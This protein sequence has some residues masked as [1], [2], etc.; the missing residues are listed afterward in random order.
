[1]PDLAYIDLPQTET[2]NTLIMENRMAELRELLATIHPA[3][4]AILLDDLPE[5]QA[6]VVFELLPITIASEVLDET[7][8]LVRQ[9]LVEK[10]DD[11]ILAD[12]LDELPMDDAAEFVADLPDPVAERLLDLM[13]PEEAEDVRELLR[14]ADE[15]AGRLM[16]T[17]VAVL[18]RHWSA[19]DAIDYLRNLDEEETLHYLYVV[20]AGNVLIGIV[21]LRTLMLA[22]PHHTID[23]LMSES[24]AAIPVTADQEEL[25]E[26]ISRYDYVSIPVVDEQG[27]FLG[28]VTVDDALDVIEEEA[29]EDIQRLGGSE[30]LD[31]PY[32]AVTVPQ[33]FRKRIGWLLL[34][35]V[36]S[37]LTGSV[38]STFQ[39]TLDQVITLS[40]FIPLIIGTGGN[41][42]SQTVATIIRAITLQEVKMGNMIQAIGREVSV[43]FLLGGAMAVLGFVRAFM[44]DTGAEV[45]LVVALTLPVVVIWAVTIATLIPTLADRA[46]IDPTVISGPMIT[47]IVDATGLLI[48]F[49]LARLILGI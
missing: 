19:A 41:A 42:G 12:L 33:V 13:E 28:V 37:T 4:I 45:A 8:S 29:T 21:P 34:L 46:R 3:D 1:M 35:F 49:L 2:I 39:G 16:T 11:E 10:V 5:E 15:T 25:A 47:T 23:T 27:R 26:F 44:W 43:G 14:Y 32:F 9:E 30:P 17:D 36:A 48:Y 22:K 38:I 20:D 24:V 7:G 18:R 6:V 31:Q 40:L